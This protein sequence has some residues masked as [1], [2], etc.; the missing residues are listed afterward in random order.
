MKA[1]VCFF[2]STLPPAPANPV[3]SNTKL[4]IDEF[5]PQSKHLSKVPTCSQHFLQMVW[6]HVVNRT[7]P[8][9]RAISLKQS[10]QIHFSSRMVHFTKVILF[11]VTG[12]SDAGQNVSFLGAE[13]MVLAAVGVLLG[14]QNAL[15]WAFVV[16]GAVLAESVVF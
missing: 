15:S 1:G 7:I 2:T 6:P 5:T 14:I 8:L 9:T 3:P 13:M 10:L 12:W 16:L 4:T 11:I